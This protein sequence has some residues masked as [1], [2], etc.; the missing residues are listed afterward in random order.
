MKAEMHEQVSSPGPLGRSHIR[1]RARRGAAALAV[2]LAAGVLGG[3]PSVGA[4]S[5]TQEC[6]VP[7]APTARPILERTSVSGF[8][9]VWTHPGPL[10]PGCTGD[11]GFYV[12][13]RQSGAS[14]WTRSDPVAAGDRQYL[15]TGLSS[16]VAYEVQVRAFNTAGVSPQNYQIQRTLS[17]CEEP[18]VTAEALDNNVLRVTWTHPGGTCAELGFQVRFKRS[19]EPITNHQISPLDASARSKEISLG[20]RTYDVWVIAMR[21]GEGDDVYDTR[22]GVS[23]EVHRV[24]MAGGL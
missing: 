12:E 1:R 11:A 23:S 16:G 22:R 14:S 10:G 19:T 18:Q 5:T 15:I 20:P 3:A 17:S 2:C 24:T 6:S 13:H 7:A 9:V 8:W 4:Q 21:P